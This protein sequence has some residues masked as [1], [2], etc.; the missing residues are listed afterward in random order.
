MCLCIHTYT[1]RSASLHISAK[2]TQTKKL[3]IYGGTER[4]EVTLLFDDCYF[5]MF[6]QESV[7]LQ[8]KEKQKDSKR[9]ILAAPWELREMG[10][11]TSQKH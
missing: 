1:L 3:N 5:L 9:L 8:L 11:I 6:L 7:H 4:K 10:T 2:R